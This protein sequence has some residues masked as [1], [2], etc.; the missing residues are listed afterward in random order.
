MNVD[1]DF[2]ALY[3]NSKNFE[4]TINQSVLRTGSGV[5]YS[6]M[7]YNDA[8][9]MGRDKCLL[10][11]D[12]SD[13]DKNKDGILSNAEILQEREKEVKR[14]KIDSIIMGIFA[15]TDAVAT[16]RR[17][18]LWNLAFTTLFAGFTVDSISTKNKLQ[19]ANDIVRQQ[20]SIRA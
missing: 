17:P 12:F 7:T 2:A 11:R 20:I 8:V 9:L 15:L 5:F 3:K 13:V 6:G 18:S 19:K 1:K 10:R 14:L 4:G 16:I